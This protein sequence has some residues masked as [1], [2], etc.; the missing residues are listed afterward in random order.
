MAGNALKVG[1]YALGERIAAGGM[2][3]VHLGRLDGSAGFSR[4][5]AIK[6]LHPH[7]CEDPNF[8]GAFADEARLAARIRHP[9]VVPTL[10]VVSTEGEL[11][12]VMEYVDGDSLSSLIRKMEEKSKG[13]RIPLPIVCAVVSEMLHGL[14]SAHEAKSETGKPLDIV[15]RDVSPQNVLVGADGVAR[16]VDFGIARASSKTRQATT[17]ENDLK[18][19]LAYMAPE[20]I[21]RDGVSRRTDIYAAGIVLWELLTGARLFASDNEAATMEKI[22]VG[23]VPPPCTVVTDLPDALN[24]ITLRALDPDP[25]NRF[26]TAR[27]MAVALEDALPRALGREVGA[28]VEKT[29]AETLS[30]RRSMIARAE[31]E[32]APSR[33]N[34]SVAPKAPP[35]IEAHTTPRG[36]PRPLREPNTGPSMRL[37]ELV[38]GDLISEVTPAP[39]A[40]LQIGPATP[41]VGLEYERTVTSFGE[42]LSHRMPPPRRSPTDRIA[43]GVFAAAVLITI[44]VALSWSKIRSVPPPPVAQLPD[45]PPALTVA[46][47]VPAPPPEP[48]AEKPIGADVPPR[49]EKPI[50]ADVPPRSEKIERPVAPPTLRPG[51]RVKA[52]TAA[53]AKQPCTSKLDPATGKTIYQGDCN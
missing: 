51:T 12:I 6:R 10:D 15:H 4:T 27:E 22:L 11:L 19:K 21:R 46:E 29:G 20:Q 39:Q 34:I 3:T 35:P 41:Q 23:W 14:H 32:G 38:S 16:L 40:V 25:N 7:L 33:T 18:G 50:G 49:S 5:V 2:A 47:P 8:T 36:G 17:G 9:N 53:P 1:R 30:A 48:V 45:E 44:V 43:Y 28:W 31:K 13:E 37:E 42:E 52:R 24:D 26:E